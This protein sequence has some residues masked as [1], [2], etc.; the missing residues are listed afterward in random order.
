M[1]R[2]GNWEVEHCGAFA[3]GGAPGFRGARGRGQHLGFEL[4]ELPHEAE[5]GRDDAAPLFDKLEGLLEPHAVRA[6]QVSQTDG[7]G[8]RD[9][10]LTVNEDTSTF[11]PYRICVKQGRIG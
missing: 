7:G 2:D 1:D 9:P 11:I 5:V 8:A 3:N 4:Q 10:S 6:H